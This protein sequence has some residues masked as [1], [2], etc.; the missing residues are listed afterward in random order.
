MNNITVHLQIHKNQIA[1]DECLRRFRLNFPNL[2]MHVHGDNGNDFSYLTQTYNN[3]EYKHWDISISPRGLSN[4]NWR[5]YLERVLITCKRYPNEWILFLEED[6][7]TLHNNVI[8]PTSDFAGIKGHKLS[9]PLTKYIQTLHPDLIDIK[10]NTCGGSIAKMEAVVKSIEFVLN[11][12]IDMDYITELD[13]R[14]TNYSDVLIS[15]I[16][17]LNGYIY[18]EWEQL[19]ETASGVYK[20]DAVF[21]HSWKEFYNKND[22]NKFI[23]FKMQNNKEYFDKY[24]ETIQS[25]L[26]DREK[27]DINHILNEILNLNVYNNDFISVKEGDVVIDIGVNFGLFSLDALQ[28]NP[29]KIIGYE[30]N[31]KLIGLFKKLN[32]S[33]VELNQAAV[34]NKNGKTTFYE[35]QYPCRSSLYSQM[36]ADTIKSSYEVDVYDINDVLKPHSRIDYFKVDC[37]GAEYEIFEAIDIDTLSTKI[38]KIAVEFHNPPTDS[39]VMALI[40]KIQYAGFEV[41]IDFDGTGTTGMLYAKK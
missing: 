2:P 12:N 35:N 10:Y 39:K 28:Y 16:L 33:N 31:P 18:S 14:V 6:V 19:S 11:G 20:L 5:G 32:L 24:L 17:L 38:N 40:S 8:F 1:V 29:S 21:D 15:T 9:K 3:T 30:P 26:S 41:K 27:M 4:G 36:S 13:Y 34:S 7:N 22:W 23:N 37:E 25:D